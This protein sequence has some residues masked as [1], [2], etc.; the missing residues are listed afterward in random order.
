MSIS[1]E[2]IKHLAKLSN[3]TLSK[4]EESSLGKELENI[5][6]YISQLDELDVEDVEPTY[7]VFDMETV[8]REDEIEEQQALRYDLL[9]L[10]KETE[11]NQ[12]K[13]PKVL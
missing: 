10:T 7:Q 3:I 1:R 5:I 8:W 6:D 4:D 11:N 13:I 12:I 9:S 2:E